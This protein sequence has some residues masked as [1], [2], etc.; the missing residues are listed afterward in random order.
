M[1]RDWITRCQVQSV[2]PC[3]KASSIHVG[4]TYNGHSPG[5]LKCWSVKV[6]VSENRNSSK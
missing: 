5:K 1:L 3:M 4:G 2:P 6:N